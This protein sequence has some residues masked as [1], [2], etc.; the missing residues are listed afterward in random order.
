M[1]KG[2]ARSGSD[3][4]VFVVEEAAADRMALHRQLAEAAVLLGREINPTRY[5]IQKLAERL[6]NH[7]LPGARF[8]RDVLAGPKQWVAGT[9]EVLA[10]VAL[11]AGISFD[12]VKGD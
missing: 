8:V 7:A 10:P 12:Q 11:A 9:P 3:V 6:G 4:D 2:T 1:Q 5:T